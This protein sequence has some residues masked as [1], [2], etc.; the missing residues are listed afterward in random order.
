MITNI[1]RDTTNA[2]DAFRV[3]VGTTAAAITA[4]AFACKRGVGLKADVGNSGTIYVGPSDVTA[5]ST[6]ATDGW[7]LAAGEELF[8]PLDD[9]RSLYAIAS[10]ASQQLHVVVV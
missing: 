7:P 3:T 4:T 1:E 2:L 5:G 8:L 9:P 6:P 10:A